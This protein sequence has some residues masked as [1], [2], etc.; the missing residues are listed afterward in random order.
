MGLLVVLR[1]TKILK[2]DHQDM[3]FLWSH[4]M[5]IEQFMGYFRKTQR[6]SLLIFSVS[7]VHVLSLSQEE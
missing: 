5:F 3:S 1:F 7:N 2:S 4:V 6:L